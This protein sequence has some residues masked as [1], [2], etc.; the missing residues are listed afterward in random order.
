MEK[1]TKDMLVLSGVAIASGWGGSWA[2]ARL[3]KALGLAL[4]PWGV[5]AGSIIGALVGTALAKNMLGDTRV[6]SELESKAAQVSS[7]LESKVEEA[8][9][10]AK[11]AIS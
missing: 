1:N 6:L 5:A 8:T 2:T 9:E 7:E 10:A 4:G 11:A 3:G